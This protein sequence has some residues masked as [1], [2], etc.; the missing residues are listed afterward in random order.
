M[1][2]K[3]GM[4][5]IDLVAIVEELREAMPLWVGKIYQFDARTLGIRLNGKEGRH[6]KLLIETSRRI[7]LV[8]AFPESPKNPTG[9][10]MLLRK[11]LAGG[12][13][14]GISQ[15]S[16]QRILCI[17]VG[18]R[19]D[20]C[21]LIIE[22]FGE[23]NAVLCDRTGKI[24]MPLLH[25]QFRERS[26]APGECYRYPSGTDCMT[27]AEGEL[28]SL[29]ARAD[30]EIVRVL[31]TDC[32][33]GGQ[34]A[35][36]LC[37]RLGI[38]KKTPS[39]DINA[40]ALA[41][42]MNVLYEDAKSRRDPVIAR[43]WCWPFL[44]SSDMAVEHFQ[45]F[46]RALE[47]YYG[48]FAVSRKMEKEVK[49]Q[50]DDMIRA[51]QQRAL[52]RFENEIG[53][54]QRCVDAI[55]GNYPFVEE[56]IRVLGEASRTRSW[57]EIKSTLASSSH[58][59]AEKIKAYHPDESAIDLDLGEVVKIFVRESL[60]DNVARYYEAIK[61]LKRKREGALAA[62]SREIPEE[63]KERRAIAPSKRR[64][65]HR[66]RWFFTR[67]GALVIGG[68]DADQ[69]EEIVKRYMEKKDIF[70]HADV[71]GASVVLLKGGAGSM[72][73]AAA[74]AAAYSGAWKSGHLTADVFAATPSQVSKTAPSGEYIGKGG[75]MVRGER[76][77]FRNI[78]LSLAIGVQTE[79]EFS[80]IGGPPV[81]ISS[82]ARVMVELR[83]GKFEAGDV[84][85]KVLRLLRL[86]LEKAGLGE[87]A[88]LVRS[89]DIALFIPTG[90]SD[91]VEE[92]E[93]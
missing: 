60:Q 89:E 15:P 77:Y 92:H 72:E 45:T 81:A 9:F 25:Q 3:E 43:Q 84:T 18:R 50:K 38:D 71:H 90:G 13:V 37:Q 41:D 55:Y 64:W 75:F 59:A 88:R 57:N 27:L 36:E 67:D 53:R 58:P 20:I 85:K 70:L 14:L 76:Q 61:K 19:E 78:P 79:P 5:G 82:R 4:S 6:L 44:P 23:G 46:S 65:Y 52:E 30:K 49:R 63:E 40:G 66:F 1:A 83:P 34:Y 2:G 47:R 12:R 33:F 32:L 11:H 87:Y 29:L 54:L 93:G 7:H 8:E 73:E 74:F 35:E 16:I 39:R 26:I 17:E 80:V 69:N 10:A 28:G 56:I 21:R 68:R 91:I 31:A 86:K 48:E 22:M 24:I 42:A 62:M 51:Q